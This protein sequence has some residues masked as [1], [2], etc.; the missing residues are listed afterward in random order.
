M[1][2]MD[3]AAVAGRQDLRRDLRI[4]LLSICLVGILAVGVVLQFYRIGGTID[5]Y[6]A[7]M[8]R[9][10]EESMSIRQVQMLLLEAER[11]FA[12][13]LASGHRAHLA[14][15]RNSEAELAALLESLPPRLASGELQRAIGRGMRE[16]VGA[17]LRQL[18][19]AIAIGQDTA[20]TR[21][22]DFVLNTTEDL[23][24]IIDPVLAL[25][26]PEIGAAAASYSLSRRLGESRVVTVVL[27]SSILVLVTGAALT[28]LAYLVQRTRAEQLLVDA[29]ELAESA[30]RAK[31]EFVASMS[32]EIRTPLTSIIGY[33]E[34]LEDGR[35]SAA[36]RHFVEC[37]RSSS[38]ALL[39]L[40]N[41]ILD[42]S[43][44]EA[45]EISIEREAVSLRGLVSDVLSI[46]SVETERKGIELFRVVDPRL[47]DS[48]V[49]DHQR[50]RQVLLNLLKNAVKFTSR[51]SV[52][53]S[54][55]PVEG[56]PEAIRFVVRDTGIGIAPQKQASL[57]Q[58][59]SQVDSSIEREYGGT[60]LGL[61]ISRSLVESMGGAIGVESEL[62][63]GSTFWFELP[64]PAAEASENAASETLACQ[65][66]GPATGRILLA[67]DSTQNQDLVK[68]ILCR[69][70]YEVDVAPNGLEA[71]FAV[72][73]REYA[74]VLMD[75]QMPRMNGLEATRRIRGMS[76]PKGA[77][78][79]IA[80][81]ANVLR[82]HLDMFTQAGTD[83][84]VSKP[85][86]K[87]NLLAIVER[88]MTAPE[89][90][91]TCGDERREPRV[92]EA[93]ALEEARELLGDD[94][95]RA[96]LLRLRG[97]LASFLDDGAVR[98]GRMQALKRDAHQIVA[99]AGQLGFSQLSFLAGELEQACARG[100]GF[101][102]AMAHARAAAVR[103]ETEISD[104][105]GEGRRK[106]L[107]VSVASAAPLRRDF[108]SALVGGM[109]NDA[110]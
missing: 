70:G 92:H 13:F 14:D 87:A 16:T 6:K 9:S 61:A 27:M 33:T 56:R 72:R 5:E 76:G 55:E 51:G 12:A 48:V 107:R 74:L 45:G 89:P 96:C 110:A 46:I 8:E 18:S 62:G 79:I 31:S 44:I 85:F 67:E 41:D 25:G 53:L 64:L 86:R 59:F 36:Q 91:R 39:G 37:L 105:L 54:M 11:S 103:A 90:A 32:H 15:F 26:S 80:M 57:F 40:V 2:R 94:W 77:I 7:T 1:G 58:R 47:P 104:L 65:P 38:T 100:T 97:N 17:R 68:A 28:V 98:G 75:M 83:D 35:L 23:R 19:D 102:A 66:C 88:W 10:A 30:N 63:S 82:E 21:R 81:T 78:P 3:I 71:V 108:G 24:A 50:L 42:F 109:L 95:V 84:H 60:G 73:S 22:G 4:A 29:R 101:D 99:D 69:A 43:K 52:T 106:E 93:E 20:G 49:A 34:L